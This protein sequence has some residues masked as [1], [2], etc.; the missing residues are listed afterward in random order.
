MLN[1][2]WVDGGPGCVSAVGDVHVEDLPTFQR[3]HVDHVFGVQALKYPYL[4]DLVGE[5]KLAKF[6]SSFIGWYWLNL[7]VHLGLS[8]KWW[9]T[10]RMTFLKHSALVF[11][12]LIPVVLSLANFS[13]ARYWKPMSGLYLTVLRYRRS[14]FFRLIRSSQR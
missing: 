13:R 12:N 9:I 1:Q 5:R 11:F 6:S 14:I 7:S 3:E 4:V 10:E 2:E 8:A